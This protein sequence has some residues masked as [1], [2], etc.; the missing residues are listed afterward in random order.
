MIRYKKDE[1]SLEDVSFDYI[2]I[3]EVSILFLRA[4]YRNRKKMILEIS[5]IPVTGD[6]GHLKVL[7]VLC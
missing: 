3:Q 2:T 7:M 4:K 5:L 1:L 6:N